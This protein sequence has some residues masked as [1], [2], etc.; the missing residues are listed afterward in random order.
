MACLLCR[1]RAA[2][3]PEGHAPWAPD[4]GTLATHVEESTMEQEHARPWHALLVEEVASRLDTG[5]LGLRQATAKSRLARYGPNQL[6]EA[7]PTSALARL[8]H[9]F[10]SPLIYILL[11][12][13]AVTLLL[14]KTIDA[15]AIAAILVINAAIGFT[16][17]RRAEVS[18]RALT[19]LVSPR[20]RV[21][22]DGHEWEVESRELVPGDLVLLESG[23]RVPADLRLVAATTLTVDESL[24]TG[25][26]ASVHK[27]ASAVAED[28]PL[29]D[30]EDMAYTGT[31]VSSGRGRG[32]VVATG[33]RTELGE[34]AG[35][36]RGEAATATPL[37]ERMRRF[38]RVVGLVVGGSS[39]LGFLIGVVRGE[40]LSDMFMLAVALAV[41]AV[42]EGLPVV[43]TITLALGVA[44]MARRRAVIRRLPAIETLGST[45]VIGSD[46][47]GTLTE[48]RMT[49]QELW[50]GGRFFSLSNEAL[51]EDP[52]ARPVEGA[53]DLAE[54]PPLY[55]LLLTGVL[56]NEADVFQ[57]ERGQVTRGDPTEAA[58]LLAA[59]RLG[60]AHEALRGHWTSDA[61]IPFE[62]ERQYSASMR[63]R[64]GRRALFVKGAPERVL[65]MSTAQLGEAGLE[66]LDAEAAHAAAAAL[67]GRGLRMLAMAYRPLGEAPVRPDAVGG[68]EGL[69]FLGL[70]GMM[71]PPREGV[72]EAI[73]RCQDAGIRV[74]MVTGDHVATARAIGR[75]LGLTSD[76]AALT[77]TELAALDDAA[78]LG[79]ALEVDLYA[80]VTPEQKLRVVRALQ[81]GGEVVAVTGD[82]V[83]D[84]PALKAADIG[85]AMGRG[86][87]D[88]AR[89]A[90]DM[91]LADDNFVS[92]AAAVEEGRV[93]FDNLRKVTFFLVSTGAAAVITLLCALALGWPLPLLPA[94]LLWLNL[95]TNGLQDV[96]LAFEPA[97]PGVMARAPRPRREGFLSGLLWE[98]TVVA[99]VV[100]ATGTLGVFHWE[101]ARTDSLPAARTAAL[102]TMVL[103]QMFQVGNARSETQSVFA[104]SP[105]SNPFLF[106]ATAAALAVH[107]GALYFAPTR[108]VLR[109][110]PL[111]DGGSWLR[112][113][114]VAASII[115][116]MEL[117]KLLRRP[118]ARD[119]PAA[120]EGRG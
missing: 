17:E 58:L 34:I 117:H 96:A 38:A 72:R 74:V 46:K 20:T 99:G 26:S 37:Q 86:G 32:Y 50:A 13:F 89:E 113:V 30:R 42:P 114:L 84:A 108:F 120:R 104:R 112:I 16:Q 11:A 110:V 25:E 62:P 8:L 105:F 29:P 92:I 57:T 24:L 109:V 36:I 70:T 88:V 7:P 85:V 59:E 12:A 81:A 90:S 44:R 63:S 55:L 79:R 78:L 91:V 2:S 27:Q 54:H 67:A 107:V 47:T 95:V 68:P 82:G 33:A 19:R 43:L 100:M 69:T 87:T 98:R 5:A 103:F 35:S 73:A 101:L 48:N 23:T 116:A 102:T 28:A 111:T 93:T 31:V 77:G 40:S 75:E 45:T 115:V 9:Q 21:I 6:A 61:E 97:D 80:R 3:F 119:A 39:A 60:L 14:G 106:W 4:D 51:L 56:A 15:G 65:A 76:G 71:D 49:V 41:A 10:K 22:R 83:N 52:R 66:P 53:Q 94:Q 64:D 1:W 18:V 118:S